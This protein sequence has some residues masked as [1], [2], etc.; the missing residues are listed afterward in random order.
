MSIKKGFTLAEALITMSIIGIIAVMTMP[1]LK[2]KVN[3]MILAAR[4]RKAFTNLSNALDLAKAESGC[5]NYVCVFDASTYH[6]GTSDQSEIT[7]QKLLRH[8]KVKRDCG[9][10]NTNH[11]WASKGTTTDTRRIQT[12]PNDPDRGA[13]FRYKFHRNTAYHK[14]VLDDG[15][16]IAIAQYA[17]NPAE[18]GIISR[19]KTFFNDPMNSNL[20]NSNEGSEENNSNLTYDIFNEDGTLKDGW[21]QDT[22]NKG[23]TIY[24]QWDA[25]TSRRFIDVPGLGPKWEDVAAEKYY[26]LLKDD[27]SGEFG[28]MRNAAGYQCGAIVFDVNGNKGPNQLGADSFMFI[29]NP[30]RGLRAYEANYFNTAA[31]GRLR[32]TPFEWESEYE[33]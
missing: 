14:A 19:C 8:L 30:D 23:Q 1:V 29:I 17:V 25:E 16:N 4:A 7:A 20:S 22:N 2:V 6:G 18:G 15:T 13:T 28:L 3:D 11:C 9:G 24:Y 26:Y 32:Y 31:R 10:R 21:R 5:D 33:N 12:A 27:K